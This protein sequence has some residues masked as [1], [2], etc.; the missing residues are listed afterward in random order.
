[1]PAETS[2][3]TTETA[4]AGVPAVQSVPTNIAH[5]GVMSD[6]CVAGECFVN[7][8]FSYKLQAYLVG[9]VNSVSGTRAIPYA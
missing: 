7:Q 1:M 4:Y 8:R 5:P 2:A 9:Y 3:V 6:T